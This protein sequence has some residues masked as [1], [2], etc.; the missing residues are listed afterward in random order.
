MEKTI[1]ITQNQLNLLN[2]QIQYSLMN[3][4]NC[5]FQLALKDDEL[6]DKALKKDNKYGFTT[7][8]LNENLNKGNK[9]GTIYDEFISTLPKIENICKS[10]QTKENAAEEIKKKLLNQK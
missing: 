5:L 3:G 7:Q 2:S 6:N 10:D 8:A 1:E 9:K 4:I